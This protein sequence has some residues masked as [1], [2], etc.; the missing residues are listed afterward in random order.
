[1][2]TFVVALGFGLLMDPMRIGIAAVLM[3][4]RRAVSNLLAFWVGGMVAGLSVGVAV[5]VFLHDLALAGIQVA[6]STLN[7]VRSAVAILAGDRI[8][9][10]VGVISLL[11]VAALLSQDRARLKAGVLAPLPVPVGAGGDG[12]PPE[13][14]SQ[15]RKPTLM[16][17][18]TARSQALLESGGGWPAF[19][20]GLASTFP[21]VEGPMALTVI[22]ASKSATGMQLSAFVVFTALVLTFVEIPL[23]GYLAAP[24]ATEA[25][26][27]RANNWIHVHRR[28]IIETAFFVSGVFALAKGLG[29]YSIY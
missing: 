21:P 8:H 4:R 19:V 7:D 25:L 28:Q 17:R 12:A 26:M 14:E 22:M 3:S 10:T 20:A 13:Q 15:P 2:W 1:M 6:A 24:R 29:I 23:L 11:V 16:A 9:V 27:L 5:L 18:L